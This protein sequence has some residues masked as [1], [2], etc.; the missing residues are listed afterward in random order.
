MIVNYILISWANKYSAPSLVSQYM[1]VQPISTALLSMAAGIATFQYPQ[2][3]G[4]ILIAV[5]LF[6]TLRS[7]HSGVDRRAL[8]ADEEQH[9]PDSLLGRL[10]VPTVGV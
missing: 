1:A 8:A 10:L 3:I 4:G 7:P 6:T 5:G 2:I 9:A